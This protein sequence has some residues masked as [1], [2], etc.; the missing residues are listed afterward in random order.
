MLYKWKKN[1]LILDFGI[2][3]F[4]R[5]KIYK[6]TIVL[7]RLHE[8]PDTGYQSITSINFVSKSVNHNILAC[9]QK[10]SHNV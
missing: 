5:N 1:I 9:C 10:E 4:I 7:H 2:V 3:F 6:Y 8:A